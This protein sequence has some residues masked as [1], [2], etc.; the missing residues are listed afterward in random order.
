M[1]SEPQFYCIQGVPVQP[2]QSP[3]LRR[4]FTAWAGKRE[5]EWK[6][7]IQVSLFIQALQKFYDISFEETLSYFQI[8]GIH[9]YPGNT[10][11]DGSD[12]P[13]HERD[14][15]FGKHML[16]CTHNLVTFPTWHRPYM[17]LFE[18]SSVLPSRSVHANTQKQRIYELMGDVIEGL[19]FASD[20]EKRLWKDEASKWRLPYWDWAIDSN[21]PALFQNDSVLVCSPGLKPDGSP[22]DP[23]A[24][25]N[26][27]Y[28]YQLIVNGEPIKMG[29]EDILK[30]YAIKDVHDEGSPILPVC[31]FM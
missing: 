30:Q 9:G 4:E 13:E 27:L 22:C 18:A 1:S 20:A 19:K 10:V 24:L 26:P 3:G 7:N 6:S 25:D 16:Y 15:L 29:N 23:V 2:G 21:I 5:D 14:D 31:V 28:R 12:F 8:A 11:W 17:L